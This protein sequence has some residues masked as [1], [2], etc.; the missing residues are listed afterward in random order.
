VVECAGLRYGTRL[1]GYMALDHPRRQV[2]IFWSW[3][4]GCRTRRTIAPNTKAPVTEWW[5]VQAY[6]TG[7]G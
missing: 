5:A 2:S 1:S 4:P 7:L 6:G 3:T